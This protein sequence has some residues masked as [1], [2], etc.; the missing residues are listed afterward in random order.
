MLQF[1]QPELGVR[2]FSG[3]RRAF[4]RVRMNKKEELV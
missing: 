4:Y 1:N 2:R 3:V